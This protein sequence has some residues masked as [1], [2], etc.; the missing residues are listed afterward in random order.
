M[1]EPR[2]VSFLVIGDWGERSRVQLGVGHQICQQLSLTPFHF[3]AALGD[4]IYPSGAE[5]A[6]DE[7]WDEVMQSFE[8][9][10]C[11]WHP[12]LGNHDWE[13]N[14]QA[15]LQRKEVDS[16]WQMDD[17]Y[18]TKT[19]GDNLVQFFFVDTCILCPDVS[20]HLTG[21]KLN[22]SE[23]E[24]Q[25]EWLEH[26]LE[27]CSSKWRVVFGHFPVYSNGENGST[28]DLQRLDILMAKWGVDA[29]ICGH[30]HSMQHLYHQGRNIHHI[31]CGSSSSTRYLRKKS[32][33]KH[34][35]FGSLSPGFL[36]CVVEEESINVNFISDQGL[37]VGNVNIAKK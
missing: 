6:T 26:E 11:V 16:R 22:V 12:I 3:L 28:R 2:K 37:P 33:S 17:L 13:G 15:Q 21:K 25:Y 23:M 27:S 34:T 36:A 8:G 32:A 35:L 19:F 10:S 24:L 9:V 29:Y 18:Y 1:V 20:Y 14:P 4:N 7:I 30:D 5:T 31:V